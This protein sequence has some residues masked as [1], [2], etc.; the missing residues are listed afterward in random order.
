M[1]YGIEIS[2]LMDKM[3]GTRNTAKYLKKG[4]EYKINFELNHLI[5]LEPGLYY[6]VS[7]TYEK[8]SKIT[9]LSFT[10]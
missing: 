3:L 2:I 1:L 5:K 9:S 10:K 7:G 4:V 8:E 6:I